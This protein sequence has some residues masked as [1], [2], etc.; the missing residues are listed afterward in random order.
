MKNETFSDIANPTA[1]AMFDLDRTHHFMVVAISRIFWRQYY[2]TC[3][4]WKDSKSPY[5]PSNLQVQ[6]VPSS[7]RRQEL[8]T[9]HWK[10]ASK[11]DWLAKGSE[12]WHL[13]EETCRMR[14]FSNWYFLSPG[15]KGSN[16][17]IDLLQYST[18]AYTCLTT[19]SNEGPGQSNSNSPN[20]FLF[21]QTHKIWLVSIWSWRL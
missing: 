18:W 2:K 14:S 12:A 4:F 6:H 15:C 21:N 7:H 1:N 20:C 19:L 5:R 13:L 10:P 11:S 8:L 16:G 17:S 9:M 3:C